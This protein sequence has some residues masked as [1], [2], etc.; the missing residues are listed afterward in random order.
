VPQLPYSVGYYSS[1]VALD[2]QIRK[3]GSHS[4]CSIGGELT[5]E[6]EAAQGMRDLKIDEVRRM[7]DSWRR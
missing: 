2:P 1:G 5:T 7:E 4:I 6:D 3:I